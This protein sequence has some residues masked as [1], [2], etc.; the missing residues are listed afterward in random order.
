[1]GEMEELYT[2]A[3]LATIIVAIMVIV[4]LYNKVTTVEKKLKESDFKLKNSFWANQNNK[5]KK[6]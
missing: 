4:F 6:I 1:M 5:R 3:Q 2:R